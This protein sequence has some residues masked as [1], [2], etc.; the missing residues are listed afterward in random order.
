MNHEFASGSLVRFS[1][2]YIALI[3]QVLVHTAATTTNHVVEYYMYHI[4]SCPQTSNR[5][6]QKDR[7]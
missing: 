7:C 3:V 5:K 1:G 4:V 6:L 2:T